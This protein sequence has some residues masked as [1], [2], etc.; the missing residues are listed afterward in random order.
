MQL[1][2]RKYFEFLPLLLLLI[3]ALFISF[4]KLE[5][6]PSGVYVDEALTGYNAY[7]IVQTGKDEYGKAFPIAFRFFGS[8][9]PPLYVYL[10]TPFI[11]LFG[12]RAFSVRILSALCGVFMAVVVYGFLKSMG[13]IRSKITPVIG[14]LVFIISP[15]NVFYSRTGYE[16]Y[17]GFFLF[18]LGVFFTWLGLTKPNYLKYGFLFVSL[19]TYGS[20]TGRYLALMFLLMIVVVFRRRNLIYPLLVAFVVQIPNLYLLTTPAFFTKGDLFY[21]TVVVEQAAK[22]A[23]LPHVIAFPLSLIREF[24]SQ[25]LNYFSPRSLFFFPD[26][27][28]QR[29]APLLAVFYPWM[30]VP[31]LMGLYILWQNRKNDLG[32]Y[33][34]ILFLLIPVLPA[35]TNDP[36]STQ[37]ALP[38]LLPMIL[39]IN[40]GID[41]LLYKRRLS[42]VIVVGTIVIFFSMVLLW[43]SYFVLLPK[44]RAKYWGYGHEQLAHEIMIRGD[45]RF[46]IDQSRLKPT[47]I[48]LLF[49]MRYPAFKFQAEV[50]QSVRENYYKDVIFD[51]TYSFS[52]I[53]TRNINWEKDE[54]IRQIIVG[55]ELSVSSVQAKEHD[56]Q[57]VFEI[58]DPLDNLIFQG[59][60]TNPPKKC[61][62]SL[63]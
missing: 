3:A 7:S 56:L 57:K 48:E 22:V 28:F 31:Y 62:A 17:L 36:F 29:S 52:N 37:R 25:Y 59:Y 1:S 63:Y 16:I 41:R 10:S 61:V 19:S 32:K 20:H 43:R 44:E 13:I 55:D 54:C 34:L 49:F 8:Y 30:V 35:L 23:I 26:P 60:R 18:S 4:I 47:Y 15:W 9:S 51:N 40:L 42:L 14:T 33:L 5:R 38:L 39:I 21:K 50:K 53:E 45:E 11:Y 6:V 12:L 46:L 27:D 24:F 58:R 2:R